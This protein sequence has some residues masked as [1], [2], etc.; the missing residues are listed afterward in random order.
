[1]QRTLVNFRVDTEL[2]S[3]FDKICERR[4]V[5][6][7]WALRQF[8][9]EQTGLDTVKTPEARAVHHALS[10]ATVVDLQA[11][12]EATQVQPTTEFSTPLPEPTETDFYGKELLPG[13]AREDGTWWAVHERR[14]RMWVG[15][16]DAD[17]N[18]LIG[19]F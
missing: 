2:L 14:P 12:I 13:Y 11:T 3:F 6:R 5:S 10:G 16:R 7:S 1:M 8:M 17:G 19:D 15:E 9:R 18:A 4:G